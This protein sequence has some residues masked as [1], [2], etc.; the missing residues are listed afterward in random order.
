[1]TSE[2]QLVSI[3]N[4]PGSGKFAL[5]LDEQ[6]TPL[7]PYHPAAGDL[8]G[9]LEALPNIGVGNIA[10]TKDSN[11][12]Y[13]CTF[14]NAMADVFV[15]QFQ[16]WDNQLGGGGDVQISTV[17]DGSPPSTGDPKQDAINTAYLVLVTY[18]HHGPYSWPARRNDVI[19]AIAALEPFQTTGVNDGS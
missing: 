3:V 5:A 8:E 15:N 10:V 14:Q 9:Y 12:V 7:M 6:P 1:M 4:S 13:R 19:D 18:R 17:V 16:L 2:V 11:W